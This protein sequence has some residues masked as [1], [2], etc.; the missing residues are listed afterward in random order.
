MAHMPILILACLREFKS[1]EFA[2]ACMEH[3]PILILELLR[4]FKSHKQWH[5]LYITTIMHH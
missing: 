4:K 2:V 1:H 3:V 5:M